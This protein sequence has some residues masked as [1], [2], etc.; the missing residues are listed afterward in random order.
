[1]TWKVNLYDTFRPYR[2]KE[3]LGYIEG[4]I[5]VRQGKRVFTVRQSDL[6][7]DL[8]GKGIGLTMYSLM[9]DK[10][11]GMGVAA[12]VRSSTIRNDYSSGVWRSLAKRYANIMRRGDYY[13]AISSTQTLLGTYKSYRWTYLQT[14]DDMK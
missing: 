12:E 9:I 14:S 1:M 3:P 2:D 5:A 11:L 4:E 6:D 7:I 8:R 10:F 13:A